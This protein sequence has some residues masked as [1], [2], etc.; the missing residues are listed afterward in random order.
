MC[1]EL[2]GYDFLDAYLGVL[3]TVVLFFFFVSF[4]S[5]FFEYDDFFVFGLGFYFAYDVC[6]LEVGLS[7]V[8]GVA[9]CDEE[10]LVKGNGGADFLWNMINEY[11]LAFLGFDLFVSICYEG[12][13]WGVFFL[14]CGL[15][16]SWVGKYINFDELGYFVVRCLLGYCSMWMEMVK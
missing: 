12:D 11:G 16:L 1:H 7:N 8:C 15:C 9:F 5:F 6:V 2:L 4:S 14:H 10:D 13:G 3:L